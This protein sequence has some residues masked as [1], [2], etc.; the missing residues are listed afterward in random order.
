MSK[1]SITLVSIILL[2]FV[3][4]IWIDYTGINAW[5]KPLDSLN[6]FQKFVRPRFGLDLKGGVKF[7]LEAEDTPEVKVTKDN[8]QS[9]LSVLQRR[10]NNLGL[11]ESVVVEERGAHW[12]R[13]VVELPGWK[14]PERAK[15]LIGETAL[16]QLKTEDGKVVLTGAHIKD[17]RL[18]FSQDPKSM[19]EPIIQF[20]LDKEG[21]KIFA[22]VTS[23][24]VGKRIAIYL[25][26]KLLMNPVVQ[27]PITNGEGIIEGNFTKEEAA[28]DAA[29][30]RSGSLPVKLN[31]ISEEVVGPTLGSHSVHM[32]LIALLLAILL[33]FLYMIFFY[34]Y[35]GV[36]A[37][38]ALIIYLALEMMFLF[39]L[40]ATLSLPA[41][42]GAILSLGMAVD[43]NVIVFERM[44]EELKIGKSTRSIVSAGFAKAFRTVFDS[45]LTVLVGAIVLFYFGTGVIK[46]FSITVSIGILVGFFS[47]VVVTHVLVDLLL[48]KSA[49][50]RPKL[51]GI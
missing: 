50:N 15:K 48:P 11:S 26:N 25:D 6:S 29:L 24:N 34:G 8:I 49:S 2:V 9:T 37:S 32:A 23:K 16:L 40:H 3:L 39:L 43:I 45:N 36:L 21:A 46:G 10:V 13:I 33:I 42:G 51:F 44:K 27:N 47:G 7:V 5:N 17:A 22:D 41:I 19:G 14:D 31:F 18:A 20:T 38:L 35:L 4:A 28:D 30:L 12:K 1:K